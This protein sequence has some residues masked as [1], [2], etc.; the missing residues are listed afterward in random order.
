MH[1]K[2]H[3]VVGDHTIHMR[4]PFLTATQIATLHVQNACCVLGLAV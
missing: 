2:M 4:H 3:N 1:M